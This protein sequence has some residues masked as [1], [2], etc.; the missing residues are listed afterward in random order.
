MLADAGRAV[1]CF[2]VLRMIPVHLRKRPLRE[3]DHLS[4]LDTISMVPFLTL[5]TLNHESGCI[6]R[7]AQTV[8]FCAILWLIGRS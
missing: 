7:S 3:L 5:I 4:N 6:S 8:N 2:Y 1:V